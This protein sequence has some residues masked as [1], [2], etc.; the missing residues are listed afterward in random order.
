M[1][2]V[3]V[4]MSRPSSG[5]ANAAFSNGKGALPWPMATVMGALPLAPVE[6]AGN[7]ALQTALERRPGMF[8]RLGIYSEK[9]FAIDP[10]DCPFVFLLEP[11]GEAP[12]L[13]VRASLDGERWDARISAVMLVLLGLLDG[14]YDGDALFFTRD[15]VI[16]GDTAAVLALRNAVEDAEL[17]PGLLLGAPDIA[18][19]F[20]SGSIQRAANI[21][22]RL[23]GAPM[24][25]PAPVSTF[26]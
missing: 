25:P 4:E 1:T 26:P 20:V 19:P 8:S 10:V 9:L 12:R 13:R 23:L 2:A 5:V 11:R 22:R 18:A 7:R 6:I 17:D 16:E 21:M 3:M 14:T 15:L 24:S